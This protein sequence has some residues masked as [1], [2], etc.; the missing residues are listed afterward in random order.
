VRSW[1]FDFADASGVGGFVSLAIEG[2]G[3]WWWTA[4]VRAGEPGPVVVF[5]ADV[6]APRGASL[7]VR[8]EGLWAELVCETPDVHWGVGLE[9]FGL[10]LD[11]PADA[12]GDGRGARVAVGLDLEWEAAGEPVR[13]AGGVVQAG[14]VHGELL[15]GPD[16]VAFDG[17][18]TR[19][20]SDG[21]PWW[22]AS[23]PAGPGDEEEL[24]VV[25]VPLP[26]GALRRAL[27]PTGW[28]DR[29]T[30]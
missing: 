21:V 26:T 23:L 7:A 22:E 24:A 27:T 2:S 16:A 17:T 15:V 3:A 14:A 6:S 25:W 5:D 12:L 20:A 4:L 19:R 29:V 9:A 8:A 28:R 18:G 11:D 13:V 10:R 1:G 30:G